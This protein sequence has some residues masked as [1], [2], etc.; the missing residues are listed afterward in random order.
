MLFLLNDVVFE[1][2]ADCPAPVRD[3]RRFSPVDLDAVIELA[4]N[5]FSEE[6][7]LHRTHPERAKRLAWLIC[8][9]SEGVN[10]ALFAAPAKGCEPELVEPR[11]CALP[12]MIMNHLHARDRSGQLTPMAAD[13]TV[14]NRLAA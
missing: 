12:A 5:L 9:R 8:Q 10:A 7:E 2:D 13:R 4:C 11:F 1:L 14:W 3:Y 6:P